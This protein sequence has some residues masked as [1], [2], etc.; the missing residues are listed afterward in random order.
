M[1]LPKMALLA[2]LAGMFGCGQEKSGSVT[3]PTLCS[4]P[5]PVYP[6]DARE[7][8]YSGDVVVSAL[9]G[10]DGTVSEAMVRSSSGYESLDEA[11]L[12]AAKAATFKPAKQAGMEVAVWVSIPMRFRV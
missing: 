11:A 12:Q 2:L 5:A 9:V 10:K 8:G 7:A 4:I 1:K 3:T 6:S